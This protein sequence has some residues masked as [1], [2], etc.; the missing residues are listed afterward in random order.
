[1]S[2]STF[3]AS[4]PLPRKKKKRKKRKKGKKEKASL[5]GLPLA[6]AYI[7][8]DHPEKA[9][10]VLAAHQVP[11]ALLGQLTTVFAAHSV[12]DDEFAG[13][14]KVGLGGVLDCPLLIKRRAHSYCPR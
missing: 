6:E 10:G 8:L 12:G 11:V 13:V 3:A 4:S 7:A 14:R 5:G 9:V 2:F 1:M